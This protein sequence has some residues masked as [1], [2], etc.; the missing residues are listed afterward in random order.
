MRLGAAHGALVQGEG[1]GGEVVQLIEAVAVLLVGGEEV[2]VLA[3]EVNVEDRLVHVHGGRAEEVE[4][5]HVLD[6]AREAVVEVVR[7]LG[8]RLAPLL[9]AGEETF[10]DRDDDEL[11]ERLETYIVSLSCW[12]DGNETGSAHR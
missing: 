6:A 1:G 4:E 5:R 3:V 9:T 11:W 8:A 2:V 10:V 7:A 12:N